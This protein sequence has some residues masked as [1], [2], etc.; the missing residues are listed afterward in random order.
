M[1]RI[2]LA[3]MFVL[4][5]AL[6]ACLPCVV[7]GARGGMIVLQTGSDWCESGEDVRKVF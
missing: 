7:H 2:A 6:V 3:M 1:K 5:A 4:A